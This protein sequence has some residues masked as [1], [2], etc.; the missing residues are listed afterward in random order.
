[1]EPRGADTD[2][3]MSIPSRSPSVRYATPYRAFGVARMVLLR[4]AER[5]SP[6]AKVYPAC[7]DADR[8]V[9]EGP[10]PDVATP[11]ECKTFTGASAL[12]QALAYAHATYGYTRYLSR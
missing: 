8:W 11:S 1:M 2:D 9:V 10:R 7:G 3:P 12:A 6:P 5:R 4:D